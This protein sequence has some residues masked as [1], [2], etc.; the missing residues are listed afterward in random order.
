MAFGWSYNFSQ[1]FWNLKQPG[2]LCFHDNVVCWGVHSPALPLGPVSKSAPRW[3]LLGKKKNGKKRCHIMGF[4]ND[5]SLVAVFSGWRWLF[6]VIHMISWGVFPFKKAGYVKV[7]NISW[8][9]IGRFPWEMDENSYCHPIV[10]GLK[11]GTMK[12]FHNSQKGCLSTFA[13]ISWWTKNSGR[14][15]LGVKHSLIC[16]GLGNACVLCLFTS[17]VMWKHVQQMR[18]VE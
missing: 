2:F 18:R 15:F 12:L 8:G 11:K 6:H 1:V 16:N 7:S 10:E 5:D 3:G 4:G 13:R 17:E 14:F 9:G